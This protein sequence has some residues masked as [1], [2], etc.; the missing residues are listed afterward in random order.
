MDSV[1]RD[2]IFEPFFT[3]KPIGQ[4]TGLGLSTV[5]GIVKQS[6]GEL[7][8]T[9]APG[10]GTTFSI[11]FPQVSTEG[12]VIVKPSDAG[13]NAR[14][15]NDSARRGSTV[16]SRAGAARA[17]TQRI[18]SARSAQRRAGGAHRRELAAPD[19][20]R[21]HGCGDAGDE[22]ACDGRANTEKHGRPFACCTCRGITTTT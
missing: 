8:V 14:F 19:P 11:Y 20:A 18:S 1:T 7:Q 17:R 9:T 2:R 5:H 21:D 4:G 6:G 12:D 15:G 10:E 22:R 13:R 16:A 3:T